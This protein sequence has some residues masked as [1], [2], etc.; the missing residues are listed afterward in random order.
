MR[1]LIRT[2]LVLLV[3]L[4][5]LKTWM[6]RSWSESLANLVI[7]GVGISIYLFPGEFSDYGGK[8]IFRSNRWMFPSVSLGRLAG[9]ILIVAGAIRILLF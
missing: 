7:C 9:F 8:A 6:T 5:V 3:A 4:A 1:A 2:V